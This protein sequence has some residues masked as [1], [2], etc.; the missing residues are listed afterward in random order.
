MKRCTLLSET[1]TCNTVFQFF[2]L[3][4]SLF[5][6]FWLYGTPK[7]ISGI[8]DLR[9]LKREELRHRFSDV[10]SEIVGNLEGLRIFQC[11]PHMPFSPTLLSL[12]FFYTWFYLQNLPPHIT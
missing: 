4:Y 3:F 11:D 2:T 10:Y 5:L 12:H 7:L 1:K 9:E 6:F 8:I